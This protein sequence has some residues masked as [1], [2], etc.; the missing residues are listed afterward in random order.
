MLFLEPFKL[1]LELS[2]QK[3]NELFKGL[4]EYNNLSEM[5]KTRVK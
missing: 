5:K 1:G 3:T 4:T 2:S